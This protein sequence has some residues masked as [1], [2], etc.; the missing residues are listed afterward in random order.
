VSDRTRIA[1]TD[2]T[3]NP[4]Y[5]CTKVSPGCDNC[6]MFREMRQYGRDPEAVTRS[7]TKF[8][9][10]LKWKEPRRVFTCSWSDWFHKGADAWRAEAW[11]I[12][13]STPQHTYQIL[14][15][16]PGRIARHLPADW[17]EGY[18]NVWLGVS[19]ENQE[20]VFRV[21]Q[22]SSVPAKVR[23]ISAEPLLGPLDLDH[24]LE[25]RLVD[26]VIVGGE[27]G[28]DRVRRDMPLEWANEIR[29]ACQRAGVAFFFKQR[30]ALKSEVLDGVPD[31][32]LVR[33]YATN[34]YQEE[35]VR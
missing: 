16:R 21:G 30:S 8:S 5:G 23:F 13:K 34:H 35:S 22:L 15:K 20:H 29:L 6:Y 4:W 10:P 9:D 26:W 11:A 31:A 1:W 14:T 3:W 25:R 2:A 7:K 17:G 27:S 28:P 24:Y 12:I 18:P 19:V 32:L 33:E